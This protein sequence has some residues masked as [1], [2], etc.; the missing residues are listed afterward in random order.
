ML[1]KWLRS[2]IVTT[3][4]FALAAGLI[5]YGGINGAAAAPRIL[6]T[7]YGAQIELDDIDVALVEAH[8]D[9]PPAQATEVHG[10]GTTEGVPLLQGLL[11]EGEEFRVGKAYAEKIAARNTYNVR[12]DEGVASEG[13]IIKEYVRVTVYTY[14][15]RTAADGTTTKALDLDP[16]LI[17]LGY[18]SGTKWNE[19]TDSR[20]AERRVF[21][22]D[23]ILEPQGTTDYLTETL[24]IDPAV[25]D[26]GAYKDA[27]F[28]VEAVVDAVQTHNAEDAMMSAWGRSDMIHVDAEAEE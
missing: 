27:S 1:K 18:A 12:N 28:C 24:T 9:V 5:L 22:W 25:L 15:V 2:P 20:T 14:W 6:S 17:Q 19:D 11:A 8:A 26:D 13:N 4:L 7:F 3:V 16:S 21:Y 23:D 10:D